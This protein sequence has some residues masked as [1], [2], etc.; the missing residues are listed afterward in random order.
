MSLIGTTPYRCLCVSEVLAVMKSDEIRRCKIVHELT[1]YI[2][3]DWVIHQGDL[4]RFRFCQKHWFCLV[5]LRKK[6]QSNR[7]CPALDQCHRILRHFGVVVAF[8]FGKDQHG[9]ENHPEEC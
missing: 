5:L 7:L 8:D 2:R 1:E 3:D 4:H 9:G 6:Y